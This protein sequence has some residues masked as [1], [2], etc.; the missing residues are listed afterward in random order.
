MPYLVSYIGISAAE[1][2][3]PGSCMNATHL[4]TWITF[5]YRL[6]QPLYSFLALDVLVP[7][8][9][10]GH[11]YAGQYGSTSDMKAVIASLSL[12]PVRHGEIEYV[13][14]VCHLECMDVHESHGS[15]C[16]VRKD[17]REVG[18]D[19]LRGVPKEEI[20]LKPGSP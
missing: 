19:D 1:S 9:R 13:S 14:G 6:L 2:W 7:Q 4:Y 8:Y 10:A 16:T 18:R 3:E 17:L 5:W 12:H 20:K 11:S 15:A